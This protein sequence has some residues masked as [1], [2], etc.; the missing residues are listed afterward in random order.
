[1]RTG[2]TGLLRDI[3]SKVNIGDEFRSGNGRI[4]KPRSWRSYAVVGGAYPH[5][6]NVQT[7]P[8]SA[9][10]HHGS[11]VLSI[12]TEIG[13]FLIG[14]RKSGPP[15]FAQIARARRGYKPNACVHERRPAIGHALELCLH[16]RADLRLVVDGDECGLVEV[17]SIG[18]VIDAD[19]V[20]WNMAL[21][22]YHDHHWSGAR[23]AGV[24]LRDGFDCIR[25]RNCGRRI[26]TIWLIEPPP[27]STTD[28]L[29]ALFPA[30]ARWR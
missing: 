18:M 10:T 25:S 2:S 22:D 30:C 8:V 29:T 19:A 20:T 14:D 13:S 26:Y 21:M 24:K 12:G 5:E 28:Q 23:S 3:P 11:D 7:Q 27:G 15:C 17:G 9:S 4:T 6:R 16:R 1:M